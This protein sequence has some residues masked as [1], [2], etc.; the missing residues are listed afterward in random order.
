MQKY[1]ILMKYNVF[2][3]VMTRVLLAYECVLFRGIFYNVK[4]ITINF[5]RV[6]YRKELM[7]GLDRSEF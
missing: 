3:N 1:G 2:Y 7:Y 5:I 4:F 6:L